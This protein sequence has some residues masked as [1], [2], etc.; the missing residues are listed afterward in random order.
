MDP[1]APAGEFTPKKPYGSIPPSSTDQRVESR[2]RFDLRRLY[3]F[4]TK[5]SVKT[6]IIGALAISC[7]L[8]LASPIHFHRDVTT[9]H[10]HEAD[11]VTPAAAA[12]PNDPATNP[13]PTPT[14]PVP[15]GVQISSPGHPCTVGQP[16][17]PGTPCQI[18]GQ[19]SPALS[20]DQAAQIAKAASDAA[21]AAAV[22]QAARDAK[23]EAKEKAYAEKQAA[24]NDKIA[25]EAQKRALAA[26][27]K[28]NKQ[29]S[30]W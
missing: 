2:S 21:A 14:I 11:T 22:A 30:W 4:V 6:Y 23:R 10:P 19:P 7:L 18:P 28:T 1:E 20:P 26:Q 9:I 8:L 24:E 27:Q 25:E 3:N 15:A 13:A 17:A 12:A 5:R 16:V 29:S